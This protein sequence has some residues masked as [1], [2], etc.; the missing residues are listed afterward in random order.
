[1][2]INPIP[3]FRSSQTGKGEP[4]QPPIE[5][6]NNTRA[7]RGPDFALNLT[8]LHSFLSEGRAQNPER[9]TPEHIEKLDKLGAIADEA[10]ASHLDDLLDAC[11]AENPKG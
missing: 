8:S 3:I 9:F 11:D 4:S 5:P 10:L 7:G 1:M 2:P 6:A